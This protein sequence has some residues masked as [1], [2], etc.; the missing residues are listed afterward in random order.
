ML[1]DKRVA[2]VVLNWNGFAISDDCIKSLFE[3]SYTSFDIILVDNGSQDGSGRQLKEKHPQVI[4]LQSPV[5]AGY[6]GGNNLG[7]EYAAAHG[8]DYVMLLNNDTFVAPGFM[9][10][11]VNYMD[12]HTDVGAAQP[13]IYF[14]HD[15]KLLWNAGSF[16]NK[17]FG[18]PYT[19]GLH[20]KLKPAYEQVRDVDWITGCAFF[21]RTSVLQKS[22][23]LA[24]NMFLYCEDVDLSFRIKALGYRLVYLP[25]SV[26]FHIAGVSGKA[27]EKTKEGSILPEI[28]YYNQRNRIWLLKECTPWYFWPTVL[29]ANTAYV[30]AMLLYFLLRGRI[31]KFR[32]VLR[33]V[34]DGIL[35]SIDYS[36]T[37]VKPPDSLQHNHILLKA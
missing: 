14:N 9:E 11:L 36:T 22:G 23:L 6:A 4:L 2:V 35:H 18:Y 30:S 17:F 26:I 34:K 21:I 7:L 32:A 10:P 8:Y 3:V 20:R 31:Q 27:K 19:I 25:A 37:A 33:A 24:D 28:H 29:L 5:N 1:R 15:R 12:Q 16:Y 13:I